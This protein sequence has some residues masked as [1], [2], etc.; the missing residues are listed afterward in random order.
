MQ[1][2]LRRFVNVLF[3]VLH[4]ALNELNR[5]NH[6]TIDESCEGSILNSIDHT[7]SFL[8]HEF[9]VSFITSVDDG[10]YNRNCQDRIIHPIKKTEESLITDNFSEFIGHWKIRLKLHSDFE[11]IKNV[12]WNAI[13][14]ARKTAIEKVDCKV[15]H[16]F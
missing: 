16:L 10:I 6:E 1:A 5:P 3:I 11:G 14:N 7:Q 2:I 12:S 15:S 13:S 8:F 4:D 9:F